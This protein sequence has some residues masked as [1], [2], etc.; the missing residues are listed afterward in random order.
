MESQTNIASFEKT[1]AIVL[2][3]IQQASEDDQ[4]APK[5]S[6]ILSEEEAKTIFD[7]CKQ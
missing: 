4:K 6:P 3:I 7:K 5:T 1:A 2:G